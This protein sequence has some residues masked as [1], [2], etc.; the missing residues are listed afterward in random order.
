MSQFTYIMQQQHHK[1]RNNVSRGAFKEQI[2][3]LFWLRY[4]PMVVE[5]GKPTGSVSQ[6][7]PF[8][9]V[10]FRHLSWSEP[11]LH[12]N[13]FVIPVFVSHQ[14]WRISHSIPTEL[15]Q[16]ICLPV[17]KSLASR[18][19]VQDELAHIVSCPLSHPETKYSSIQLGWVFFSCDFLCLVLTLPQLQFFQAVV[20]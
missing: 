18:L 4:S 9:A 7:K 17:W 6:M 15:G 16:A 2:G 13:L 12:L 11:H 5:S 19:F 14:A 10:S 8:Q 3:D 1:C 20:W